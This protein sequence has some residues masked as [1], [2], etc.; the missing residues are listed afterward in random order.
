MIAPWASEGVAPDGRPWVHPRDRSTW[1]A[2]LIEHHQRS[3]GVHLVTWRRTTGRPAIAYADSVEEALCVGWVDSRAGRLDDV[4]STIWFS[5]RR[6]RSAW[7]RSNKERVARLAAA[8][9]MLPAG[10]AAV[11]EA[12]RRGT[13]ELVDNVEDLVVPADLADALSANAPASQHWDAFS[14]STRRGILGWIA[15]ARR[16]ETRIRRVVETAMLAERNEKPNQWMPSA[17][18][19][20]GTG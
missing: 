20:T 13:W 5:P 8:G 15:Q 3:S 16:P 9:L 2:W 6:P 12:K 14:P 4:R 1:R 17:R 19:P 11:A 18:R 7:A 10:L